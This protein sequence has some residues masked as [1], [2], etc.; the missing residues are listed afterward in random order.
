MYACNYVYV[1]GYVYV[2]VAGYLN[3]KEQLC[4]SLLRR[5]R[6]S[7]KKTFD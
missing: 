7:V 1:C 3:I 4:L 6:E 2:Y 5:H